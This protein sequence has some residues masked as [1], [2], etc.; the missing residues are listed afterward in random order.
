MMATMMLP[1]FAPIVVT[2]SA[3]KFDALSS[4]GSESWALA[5]L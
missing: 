4:W 3:A 5:S 2:Y 1:I